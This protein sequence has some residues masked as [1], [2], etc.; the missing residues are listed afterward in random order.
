MFKP[1]GN[2]AWAAMGPVF[3]GEDLVHSREYSEQTARAID[4]EI[5]RIL[6]EQSKRAKHLLT[7]HRQ[8]L[9]AIAAGL[10][11]RESLARTDVERIMAAVD[12]VSTSG[13]EREEDHDVTMVEQSQTATRTVPAMSRNGDSAQRAVR[14]LSSDANRPRHD[15]QAVDKVPHHS[16]HP[17]S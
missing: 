8:A 5:E 12:E 11:E 10:T 15:P 3:L 13:T 9:D 17:R 14:P 1:I 6:S 16:T 7:T 2:M 4:V